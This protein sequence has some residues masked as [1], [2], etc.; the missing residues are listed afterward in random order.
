MR[1]DKKK[2]RQG[3]VSD[4]AVLIFRDWFGNVNYRLKCKTHEKDN[5]ISML[6]EIENHFDIQDEDIKNFVAKQEA[7]ALND[8]YNM[9]IDRGKEVGKKLLKD[10]KE[11]ITW[12]KDKQGNII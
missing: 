4:T 10:V 7:E 8:M 9:T 1:Q 11:K 3:R 6:Q 12:R 2:K 5:G